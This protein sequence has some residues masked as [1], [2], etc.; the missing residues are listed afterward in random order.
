[1]DKNRTKGKADQLKGKIKEA[2][3]SLTDDESLK[4][5]GRAQQAGGKLQ[6]GYGRVKD[7]LRAAE[8]QAEER[9][10]RRYDRDDR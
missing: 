9:R 6:E 3:G 1:M 4:L 2:A 10:A 5:K 8:K 7:E